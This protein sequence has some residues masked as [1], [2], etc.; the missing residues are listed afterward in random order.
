MHWHGRTFLSEL[1]LSLA[2]L[3]HGWC[4]E[5]QRE[6][7][8]GRQL[9]VLVQG[10]FQLCFGISDQQLAFYICRLVSCRRLHHFYQA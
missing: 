4:I 9:S 8:Q 6:V 3:Q 7:R 2:R 5:G 1:R 10:Y